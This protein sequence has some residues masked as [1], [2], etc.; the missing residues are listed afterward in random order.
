[1]LRIATYNCHGMKNHIVDLHL[2]C[3]HN[4]LVFLQNIWLFK[5]ELNLIFTIQADF[6][7]Y[8]ISAVQDSKEIVQGR[9]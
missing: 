8:G 1:M 3:K 7:S 5:F 4:D 6:E 9:P 2:L